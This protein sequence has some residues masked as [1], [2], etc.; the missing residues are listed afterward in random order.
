[1]FGL[2]EPALKF[3]PQQIA[4]HKLAILQFGS[5]WTHFMLMKH[6]DMYF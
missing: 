4:S 6:A 2:V 3:W 5:H 1:M